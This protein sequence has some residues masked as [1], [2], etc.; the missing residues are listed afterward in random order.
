MG[1]PTE[2]AR[3]EQEAAEAAEAVSAAEGRLAAGGRGVTAAGLHKLRDAFRHADLAARGARER[4]ER[5]RAAARLAGLEEVGVQVDALAATAVAGLADAV[6]E[7]AAACA[8]VRELAAAHDA[9]VGALIE[10]AND[11]G[12]E[13]RAPG[14]P[15]KSSAFVAAS[16][17]AVL[18]K[19]AEVRQLGAGVD[20]VIGHAVAGRVDDALAA[21][22][23]V[24]DVK[25]ARQDHYFRGPNGAVVGLDDPIRPGMQAQIVS[26]DLTPLSDAEVARY[27]AGELE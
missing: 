24:V 13:P 16:P 21:A 11:L 15:R 18:H 9:Q 22:Q 3:A 10:A 7:V 25:P 6:G 12:A 5:D 26:G 1:S 2:T 19:T 14:G 20:A 23:V 17:G 27:L 4:A 8:R